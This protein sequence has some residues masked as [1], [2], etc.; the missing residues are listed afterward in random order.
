MFISGFWYLDSRFC[1]SSRTRILF[2][3]GGVNDG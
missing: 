2:K 1:F 3:L